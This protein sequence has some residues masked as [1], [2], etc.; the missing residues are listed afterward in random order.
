MGPLGCILGI[1]LLGHKVEILPTLVINTI[2]FFKV[3]VPITLL[4]EHIPVPI[5]LHAFQQL[6]L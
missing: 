6:V 3:T 1:K 2:L 4:L 5:V